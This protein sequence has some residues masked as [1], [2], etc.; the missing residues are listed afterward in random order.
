M[1][2]GA[3][4]LFMIGYILLSLISFP[5]AWVLRAKH[6][7]CWWR[8]S[9]SG[10]E[11]EHSGNTTV[12]E[13]AFLEEVLAESDFVASIIQPLLEPR[14][15]SA[16]ERGENEN[17]DIVLADYENIPRDTLPPVLT[18]KLGKV[19]PA[20]GGLPPKVALASLDLHVPKGEVLGLL[21]QNGAG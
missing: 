16:V 14:D 9:K 13:Q 1:F 10:H 15:P 4:V 17:G 7:I 21:G 18:H 20:V 19:Y 3:F 5:G 2:L 11:L 6:R 12:N 8:C